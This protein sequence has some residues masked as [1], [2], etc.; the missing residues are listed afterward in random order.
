MLAKETRGR[1]DDDQQRSLEILSL[2]IERLSRLAKN[3]LDLASIEAGLMSLYKRPFQLEPVL[4]EAL[5]VFDG[6]LRKKGIGFSLEVEEELPEAMA[7]PG[8]ISQVLFNL[9]SNAVKFTTEGS[10]VVSARCSTDGF[11]EVCV[12]DTG[13]GIPAADMESIFSRFAKVEHAEKAGEGTG[14]GLSITKAIVESHRGSVWVES[15][16]GTGSSFYFTVP[17]A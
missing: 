16:V 14:L 5:Q 15:A 10:V 17:T 1:L 12:S 7:D 2:S 4:G 8:R 11:I 3:L 9:I 13:I 6:A